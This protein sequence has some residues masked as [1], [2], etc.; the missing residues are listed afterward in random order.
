M[1]GKYNTFSD[2]VMNSNNI[3]NN[4]NKHKLIEKFDTK[5]KEQ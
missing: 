4:K 5:L 2:S 1:N 3:I